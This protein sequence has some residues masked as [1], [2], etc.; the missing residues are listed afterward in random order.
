MMA[1]AARDP[2]YLAVF[3]QELLEHDGATTAVERTCTCCHRA[4]P[5]T[6]STSRRRLPC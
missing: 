3:S 1:L 6:S 2:Y 4:L 5:V